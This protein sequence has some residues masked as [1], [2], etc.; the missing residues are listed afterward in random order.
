[1]KRTIIIMASFI[2]FSIAILGCLAIFD[3]I[4]VDTAMGYMLKFGGGILLLGVCSILLGYLFKG[5]SES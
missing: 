2:V 5:S 3:V 1:M 4:A